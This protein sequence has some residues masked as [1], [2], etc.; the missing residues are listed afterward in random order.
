VTRSAEPRYLGQI[1]PRADEDWVW[2][3]EDTECTK[4]TWKTFEETTERGRYRSIKA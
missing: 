1:A 3:G 2:G 4:T